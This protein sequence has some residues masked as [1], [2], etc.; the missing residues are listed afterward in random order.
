MPLRTVGKKHPRLCVSNGVWIL[1]VP[2]TLLRAVSCLSAE[3]TGLALLQAQDCQRIR[4]QSI[5]STDAF[6]LQ[7]K[8]LFFRQKTRRRSQS[9]EV[10][11]L[12]AQWIFQLQGTF[13]IALCP[14]RD[15]EFPSSISRSSSLCSSQAKQVLQ[16]NLYFWSTMLQ[17][18]AFG[19]TEDQEEVRVKAR[20]RCLTPPGL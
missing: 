19:D 4:R 1:E 3:L 2:M 5:F 13:G 10:T 12:W 8:Q 6:L 20:R 14:A 17:D 15:R 7:I 11:F 9:I 16:E 18:R